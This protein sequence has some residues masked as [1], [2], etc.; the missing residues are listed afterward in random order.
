MTAFSKT[1]RALTILPPVCP[2]WFIGAAHDFRHHHFYG[3]VQ[4]NST[5]SES[6]ARNQNREDFSSKPSA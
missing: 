3:T 2:T 1:L 4:T 6:A 5:P